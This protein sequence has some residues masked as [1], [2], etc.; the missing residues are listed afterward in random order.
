MPFSIKEI[1][2][3]SLIFFFLNI[4][5]FASI[6]LSYLFI[7]RDDFLRNRIPVLGNERIEVSFLREVDHELSSSVFVCPIIP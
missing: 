4:N 5:F 6:T 3:S 2:N 7:L 1:T